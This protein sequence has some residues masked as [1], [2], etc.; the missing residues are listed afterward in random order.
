MIKTQAQIDAIAKIISESQV[1]HNV[2][3]SKYSV[4]KTD[5]TNDIIL[6]YDEISS[7]GGVPAHNK[8]CIWIDK[9]GNYGDCY[10]KYL[11]GMERTNKFF[12]TLRQI[13]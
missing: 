5:V 11:K 12:E 4:C 7:T 8:K 1:S 13:E 9:D 6:T 3:C 10:D 2:S